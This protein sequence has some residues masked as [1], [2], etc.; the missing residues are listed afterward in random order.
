G[1]GDSP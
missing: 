1:R